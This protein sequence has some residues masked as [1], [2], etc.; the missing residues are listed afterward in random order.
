MLESGMINAQA[1]IEI[2]LEKE[3]SNEA[4]QLIY[5]A[6]RFLEKHG[7]LLTSEEILGTEQ[8]IESLR[9]LL[10]S[11]NRNEIL[12]GVEAL[13]EYTRPFAERVM[14]VAVSTALKSKKVQDI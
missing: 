3:A 11:N 13:N 4:E 9:G 7:I 12:A 8:R 6:K 14:D 10:L 2:R 1:D 5:T